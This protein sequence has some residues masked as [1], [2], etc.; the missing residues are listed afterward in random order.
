MR[1]VVLGKTPEAIAL[2]DSVNPVIRSVYLLLE[3]SIFPNIFL[4]VTTVIS[5]CIRRDAYLV[6]QAF[7]R[8]CQRERGLISGLWP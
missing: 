8:L 1:L 3:F 7:S 4:I 2:G 5:G 6:I